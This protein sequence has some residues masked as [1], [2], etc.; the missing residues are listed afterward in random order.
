MLQ[1]DTEFNESSSEETGLTAAY[2]LAGLKSLSPSPM[3]SRHCVAGIT[4][5]EVVFNRIIVAKYKRVVLLNG[6]APNNSK[7]TLLAWQTG[8]T[9]DGSVLGRVALPPCS[10]GIDPSIYVIYP[11]PEVKHGMGSMISSSKENRSSFA[12]TITL[13]N[14][15]MRPRGSPC[16]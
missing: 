4:D 12:R 6:K 1:P 10:L 11:R 15:G 5:S 13:V 14:T 3:M 8:L 16:R 2:S 7:L 9:L